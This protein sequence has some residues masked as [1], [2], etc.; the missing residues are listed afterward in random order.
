MNIRFLIYG[1]YVV[2]LLVTN[3]HN[4]ENSTLTDNLLNDKAILQSFV[5]FIAFDRLLVL[6][7]KLDFKPSDLLEKIGK[8]INNKLKDL[9]RQQK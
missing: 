9:E 2:L 6:L 4:F 8:S 7:T 1:L 3:F 5:T